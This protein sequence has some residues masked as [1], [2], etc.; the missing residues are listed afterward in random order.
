MSNYNLPYNCHITVVAKVVGIIIFWLVSFLIIS[1]CTFLTLWQKFLCCMWL[2]VILGLLDSSK[3]RKLWSSKAAFTIAFS[4]AVNHDYDHKQWTLK[5]KKHTQNRLKS[6][7]HKSLTMI[8]WTHW[9][10]LLFPKRSAKMIDG[11]K[12]RKHQLPF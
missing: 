7:N 9:G 11:S 12:K 1:N 10:K 4:A 6:T 5:Q 3:T 2:I 8:F